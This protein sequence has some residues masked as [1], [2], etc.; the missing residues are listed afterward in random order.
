M[1]IIKQKTLL[2]IL[3]SVVLVL[4]GLYSFSSGAS[5]DV[6]SFEGLK[7]AITANESVRLTSG[8][9]ITETIQIPSNYNGSI[10]GNGNTLTLGDGVENMFVS[11]GATVD[12]QQINLDGA[13]KGRLLDILGGTISFTDSKVFNGTTN[14]FQPFI[15]N[16]KN[17]Q[18]YEGG[19][20]FIEG[21][22]TINLTNTTVENNSTKVDFPNQ[23][24]LSADGGAIFS[25]GNNTINVTGG[26]FKNNFAG[27]VE[28]HRGFNGEGGAIKL[29]D[30]STL[31][32]NTPDTTDKTT[33]VFEGN[34]NSGWNGG[35]NQ[36][37]AIEATD[38]TINI[39]GT[40]FKIVGPFDTGGAFKLEHST[41]TIKNSD[42]VI[43]D[44]L[45]F[46]GVAGGAVTSENSTLTIE[47]STF[48][49]GAGSR[50]REAGGLIQVTQ[51]GTFTMRRSTL[52]GNG[53]AWNSPHLQTAKFGGAINFYTG[54]SVTAL[55]ED[56]TIS[57]FTSEISGGGI[58][59]ANQ[60]GLKSTTNLTVKN[61]S[62][63]NN[64]AYS[65]NNTSYGG[66]MF[67]GG[68][69][70]VLLDGTT[71]SS[72]QYSATAGG[73]YNEGSLTIQGGSKITGNKAYHAVGGILNDGYLKIDDATISGNVR[74][75][76]ST[77]SAHILSNKELGGINVYAK[78]DVVITPN[79]KFDGNDVRVI[80]GQ[81]SILLT[82][83][84]TN[85]IN[86]SVSEAE[87]TS[88][89]PNLNPKFSENASRYVGYTVAKGTEG[90]TPTK[91]DAKKLHYVKKDESNPDPAAA[92]DDH[93]SIGTWDYLLNPEAN[94]IVLGQRAKLIYHVNDTN[95]KPA[96]F[97]GNKKEL[98]QIFDVYKSGPIVIEE[99][100]SVPT[101]EGFVF[102]GWYVE[103][104]K[105]RKKD[106]LTEAE[107]NADKFDFNAARISQDD[108][109]TTILDPNIINIYAG[110]KKEAKKLDVTVT[111]AWE[112]LPNGMAT[113]ESVEVALYKDDT[114]TGDTK[115]L[116][117]ENGWEVIFE[118]LDVASTDN[119]NTK[120]SYTVKEV[121]ENN[122]KIQLAD[123]LYTV[124]YGNAVTEQS[125]TIAVTN[126]YV[127]R[128]NITHE[129]KKADG[130]TLELPATII[131]RLNGKDYSNLENGTTKT[132]NA[133]ISLESEKDAAN[134]GVWSFESWD[135]D[136][137]TI[138]NADGKF[139]G[140]WT[141]TNNP[142]RMFNVAHNFISG[143][144]ILLPYPSF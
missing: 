20:F 36:G 90:Y 45:G 87:K 15:E 22:A 91:E 57:N 40:T 6:N 13:Q 54:S 128:F 33:T 131:A 63:V 58:A 140:T 24:D 31:N 125:G 14:N 38:S 62:I 3:L 103:D 44:N 43:Q 75:D 135:K 67:I 118:D 72:S 25:R 124:A 112:N 105:D 120:Y 23:P 8:F 95:D 46:V 88:D 1:S 96:S 89:S 30:G 116:N 42:F 59:V 2:A 127:P 97:E 39:Y 16:G 66:G 70:T 111:K 109:I 56:S 53:I 93:T 37:G 79:A 35:G 92:F 34:H 108:R 71:I 142:P 101:R 139:I 123:G 5:T 98:E 61:S 141:F 82:G 68:E 26:V 52:T 76:W 100:S 7:R 18:K 132:P 114:A 122:G 41:G 32:V 51:G 11:K 117:E 113:P 74:G 119:P 69:S 64:L 19:A 21:G 130:I 73:I 86:V 27:N 17:K 77:G 49:T 47:D 137:H 85:Q 106:I 104:S 110:W 29:V 126:T 12:F 9:T 81:S 48:K 28:G 10:E 133:T 50:V 55:I 80:D 107:E 121:G 134:D 83:T 138:D 99:T 94:T 60:E 115:T 143:T 84:L 129:F 144:P 65:Y 4:G 136:S 78:K 102:T